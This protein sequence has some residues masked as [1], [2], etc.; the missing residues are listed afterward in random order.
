MKKIDTDD[1]IS[2]PFR[3]TIEIRNVEFEKKRERNEQQTQNEKKEELSYR[4]ESEG[5][6]EKDR[7]KCHEWAQSRRAKKNEGEK[8]G[9]EVKNA[10]EEE[11]GSN[12]GWKRWSEDG[13]RRNEEDDHRRIK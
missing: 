13:K 12:R 8:K 10:M 2:R 11:G 9:R 6:P 4:G 7:K 1:I 5:E 3:R